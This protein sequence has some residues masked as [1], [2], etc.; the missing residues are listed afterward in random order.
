M[1]ASSVGIGLLALG[2]PLALT[3][4]LFAGLL[5][6]VPY[7]RALAGAVPAKLV[8]LALSPTLALWAAL[9]FFTV[10]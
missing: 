10:R 3:L 2:V 9:L 8:A 6:F 7:I 5:N 4:A 1:V